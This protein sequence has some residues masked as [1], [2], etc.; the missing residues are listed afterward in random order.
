V[1]DT[2]SRILDSL[3]PQAVYFSEQDGRRGA[4][5]L[6]EL[7]SPSD[8]PRFAEPFF[9]KFNADCRFRVVMS[10]DDLAKAGLGELGKRWA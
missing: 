9:L 5:L 4:V 6:I 10:P 7:D 1:G 2:L 8:I 3:K